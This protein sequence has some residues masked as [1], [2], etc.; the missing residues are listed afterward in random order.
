M[1]FNL[2]TVIGVFVVSFLLGVLAT[3]VVY[4]NGVSNAVDKKPNITVREWFYGLDDIQCTPIKH[5]RPDFTKQYYY[6]GH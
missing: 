1:K 3:V 2:P 4:H 6:E 5:K